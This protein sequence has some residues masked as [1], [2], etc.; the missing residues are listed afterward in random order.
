[1]RML[2]L[3][4]GMLVLLAM[5][6]PAQAPP[7]ARLT[8]A[9]ARALARRASP[10]LAA[11]RQFLA[12]AL[13]RGRQAAAFPNPLLAYGREQ[14]SGDGLRNSQDVIGVEQRLE[15]FG[16][17]GARRA[18][19]GFL[20][21]AAAARFDAVQAM[22][23]FE[24]IRGYAGAAAAVRRAALAAD[25]ADAFTR[26]VGVSR[27]RLAAGDV[28]GYRHRRLRLE[29]ARYTARRL[30]AIVARDSALRMLGL[31]TGLDPS[32][33][34]LVDSLPPSPVAL[35]ADSLVTRALASRP[36][37]RAARH[38]VDAA[39]AEVRLAGAERF[40]VP[41]LTAG[42][43]TEQPTAGTRLDGFMVG[44]SVTLPLWDRKSAAVD[45]ARAESARREAD[46]EAVRRETVREVHAAIDAVQA[47][48]GELAA[49]GAELGAEAGRARQA[50]EAA[51]AEGEI[52][53]LEWLD[54]VRVYYEAETAWITL[55]SEYVARRA[56][57]E[58]ATG[59]TL[60]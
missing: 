26:A 27:E 60:F 1:M 7:T 30:E 52:G 44:F 57:L 49:L 40:G 11:A 9:E 47:I 16:Q 51:Y 18:A 4:A 42:Y 12:A 56:A 31:R 8:L 34:V 58:R 13:A 21:D 15:L 29:A 17:R 39:Q 54:A 22:V 53:L 6:L 28:S 37:L 2:S 55:W 10:E 41:A 19:A 36:E 5:P 25:A 24:V 35:P 38:A 14:T 50:A 59:A 48:A 32:S 43:K 23:D 46:L 3:S 45:A 33:L 20:G